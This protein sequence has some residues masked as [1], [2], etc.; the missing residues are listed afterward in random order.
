M[1]TQIRGRRIILPRPTFYQEE[2]LK[3][4]NNKDVKYVT[5]CQS[6]RIGKTLLSCCWAISQALSKRCSVGYVCPTGDLCRRL[7]RKI[8]DLLRGSGA[9]ISSNTVDKFILFQNGS[10]ISFLSAE[11]FTRGAGNFTGGMVFD[12]CGYLDDEIFRTVFLAMVMEA[13]KVLF[14]STPNG[15]DGIFYEYFNKGISGTN[16]RYRS[17]STTLEES[18]L[19]DKQAIQ[20]IKESCTKA[21]WHQEYCCKFLTSGVSAFTGFEKRLIKEP[22]QKTPKLYAGI[23]FSAAT[24]G[25]DSTVLTIVNDK[26][27]TVALHIFERG[28]TKT[29]NEIGDLLNLYNV[30]M[31][32]AEANSI[33]QLSIEILKSKFKRITAITATNESK[34]TIIEHVIRNF[35]QEKGA[36]LDTP[37]TRMQFANF[38]QKKTKTGLK[39]YG[40]LRDSIHDDIPM[41]YAYACYACKCCSTVGQYCVS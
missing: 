3:A 18:G 32:Y 26:F 33:G 36:I 28:D 22:A 41:S 25:E 14:V 2:V 30:T 34:R 6:R 12:E 16:K 17:F 11:S 9:I 1:T 7:I 10:N 5:V 19:Y 31:C 29:L 37:Q 8:C 20:D 23:D 35:E 39:T 40:N 15:C 27:E 21:V 24:S 13:P 4:L 38:V